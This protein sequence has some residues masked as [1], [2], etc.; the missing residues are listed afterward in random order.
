VGSVALT[1]FGGDKEWRLL[2][3]CGAAWV[4]RVVEVV[5]LEGS[6]G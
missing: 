6:Q 3:G 1:M 5:L 2:C 4:S